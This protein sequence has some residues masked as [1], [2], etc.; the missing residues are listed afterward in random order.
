MQKVE[1]RDQRMRV[2]YNLSLTCMS[3]TM[4]SARLFWH[5]LAVKTDCETKDATFTSRLTAK[6]MKETEHTSSW[7]PAPD[8]SKLRH[9]F[10]APLAADDDDTAPLDLCLD[11]TGVRD[12]TS[13]CCTAWGCLSSLLVSS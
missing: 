7:Q 2:Y 10:V 6:A 4:S 12:F 8:P 5:N 11:L 9:I 3:F 1:C 13:S